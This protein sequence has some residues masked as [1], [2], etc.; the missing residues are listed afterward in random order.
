MK[1]E[2]LGANKTVIRTDNNTHI[3]FSYNTPVAAIID[4]K[5][6]RTSQHYSSTTTK[7]IN[8]FVPKSAE[9]KEQAFF[10]KLIV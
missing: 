9:E 1:L 5:E 6:Y 2:T 7:H 10:N 4:G 8:S 3:F